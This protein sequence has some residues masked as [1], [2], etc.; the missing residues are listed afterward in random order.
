MKKSRLTLGK[1]IN[2]KLFQHAQGKMDMS[3]PHCYSLDS[4]QVV[5][6][7]YGPADMVPLL[8]LHQ[9]FI[10]IRT[11]CDAATIS[12]MTSENCNQH[13]SLSAISFN[14]LSTVV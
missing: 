7:L 11:C 4:W 8:L 13:S 2:N 3:Y 10:T 14:N 1:F 9:D 6:T 12:M 5:D